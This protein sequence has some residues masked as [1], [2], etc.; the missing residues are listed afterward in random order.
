MPN[1]FTN[2][3]YADIH[4]VYGYCN[5][6]ARH[7]VREYRRRYP[8][9]RIP[10]VRVFTNT[11][12]NIVEFGIRGRHEQDR[13]NNNGIR[14]RNNHILHLFDVNRN[15]STRRA[16]IQLKVS[17]STVWR[18]LH[19]D[20]RKPFH[21]QPVQGLLPEDP[22]RRLAFCHWLLEVVQNDEQFLKHILWTD[23]ATFTRRGV[24]NYHNLHVWAHEN[25][26]ANRAHDFQQEFHVNIWSGLINN[27]VCGPHIL[28]NRLN[29]LLFLNFLNDHFNVLLEEVPLNIR[30]EMWIQL[31][32]APAHYGRVVREWLN[33]NFPRRW[34]GRLGHIAWPPRSPDLNPLDF[35]F[36]GTIKDKVYATPVQT[37]EELIIRI[38]QACIEMRN[39]RNQIF[40][41]TSALV[42]RC[43]KCVEV[44]GSHFEHLL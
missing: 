11:H 20:L 30:Q 27:V 26:H 6:N 39:D 17:Q 4:F 35:Y 15:L 1:L 13:I 32:G 22:P 25:P 33:T 7:A 42:R 43:R 37:R 40:R 31:D 5:G 2:Q 29:S 16:A 41:A 12:R 28:P 3:E 10:S 8:H 21:F 18:T 38:Q 24:V 19:A 36:W 9:R 44:E 23:E 34:I 14:R